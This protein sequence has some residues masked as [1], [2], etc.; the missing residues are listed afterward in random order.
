[1]AFYERAAQKQVLGH[2]LFERLD[3]VIYIEIQVVIHSAIYT[4]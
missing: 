4:L 2:S 3:R 1:M